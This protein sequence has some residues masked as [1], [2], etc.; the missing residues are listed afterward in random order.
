MTFCTDGRFWKREPAPTCISVLA[1]RARPS[2]A[3][4]I[5][6]GDVISNQRSGRV[7]E[8]GGPGTIEARWSFLRSINMRRAFSGSSEVDEC[9]SN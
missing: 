8:L 3:L 7:I 1:R 6:S 4:I 2:T 5:E 9:A